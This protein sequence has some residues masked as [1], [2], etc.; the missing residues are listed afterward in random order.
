MSASKNHANKPLTSNTSGAEDCD[1]IVSVACRVPDEVRRQFHAAC[2]YRGKTMN[3]VLLAYIMKCIKSANM[4]L[5]AALVGL[6]MMSASAQVNPLFDGMVEPDPANSA[7]PPVPPM[8]PPQPPMDMAPTSPN[9][10]SVPFASDQPQPVPNIPEDPTIMQPPQMPQMPQMPPPMQP[11][12]PMAQQPGPPPFP[13]SGPDM[14]PPQPMMPP[15]P[16]PTPIQAR[17]VH[18]VTP[19]QD[20]GNIKVGVEQLELGKISRTI[21]SSELKKMDY[22]LVATE[23]SKPINLVLGSQQVKLEVPIIGYLIKEKRVNPSPLAVPVASVDAGYR[24]SDT[25]MRNFKIMYNTM[26]EKANVNSTTSERFRE[27]LK[28][29]ENFI[30]DLDARKQTDSAM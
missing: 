10:D 21:S 27:V 22:E 11:P 19:T 15:A 16:A 2:V 29:L 14:Q 9:M 17:P 13:Q 3:E 25:D 18:E 20:S 23:K 5:V 7:Q 12:V 26:L 6:G 4:S 28:S 1:Q 8:P 24:F 30:R